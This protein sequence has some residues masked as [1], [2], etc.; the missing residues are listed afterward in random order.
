[1]LKFVTSFSKEGYEVY[2]EKFLSTW[3]RHYPLDSELH[4]YYEDEKPDFK[5][6]RIIYKPLF[7]VPG[8]LETIQAMG[9]FQVMQGVLTDKRDYRFDVFRFSRKTFAQSDAAVDHDDLLVWLDAD[10]YAYS[11][12][13]EDYIRSLLNTE[14]MGYLG[15][16]DWHSC[17]SFVV[18][19]CLHKQSTFFWKNYYM[20]MVTGRFLFL[21]EWHDSY[22]LDALRQ[23]L[24]IES[25]NLAEHLNLPNG[26][27]N[28]FDEVF[29]GKARHKKGNQKFGPQRYEQLIEIVAQHKPNNVMEIGTWRGER[30]LQMKNA[31]PDMSYLGFDLFEDASHETDMHEKNVKPHHSIEEVGKFLQSNNLDAM[32]VKGNT[33]ETIPAFI[34][35]NPDYK[36][37]LIYI[38][39]GHAVETIQNDLNNAYK[40]LAP[41]GVIV[42]DDYYE[43]MPNTD[44]EKWGCNTVIE[45]LNFE[46]L[47]VADPVNGGGKVKMAV[48]R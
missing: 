19:N 36:A 26:P 40:V 47:P 37:D 25:K 14:F 32:L 15:R 29:A 12:V 42:L 44:L 46:L 27:V 3:A 18:W 20:L 13:T 6:P 9:H 10:T 22:I 21:P 11:D 41:D 17:A 4:V 28:V 39:G 48:I 1:M 43:D 35:E 33:N 2:G 8:C 24:K 7:E 31:S 34:E 23:S 5:H 30:A 45:K 16:P 38:D